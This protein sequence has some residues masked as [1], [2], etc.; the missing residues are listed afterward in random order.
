MEPLLIL[1][2]GGALVSFMALIFGVRE[3][4]RGYKM[5][6]DY[7]EAINKYLKEEVTK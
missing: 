1:S 2:L 5:F 6:N 7:M 3:Y 4:V